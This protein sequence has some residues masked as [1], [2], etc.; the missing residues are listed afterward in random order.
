MNKLNRK[1]HTN[2][3]AAALEDE[4]AINAQNPL[5]ILAGPKS[6]CAH[7]LDQIS[8][9][10]QSNMD[11]LLFAGRSLDSAHDIV[12]LVV[13]VIQ[14]FN[15]GHILLV[16]RLPWVDADPTRAVLYSDSRHVDSVVRGGQTSLLV[17]V[18]DRAEEAANDFVVGL[19]LAEVGRLL[20]H[21]QM[22]VR[23]W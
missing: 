14:D 1:K 6:R 7:G 22:E 11:L 12:Q 16:Q 13:E 18:A 23:G 9:C 10:K 19:K 20:E 8:S 21:A 4:G 17:G 2:I 5:Q 3:G 15:S